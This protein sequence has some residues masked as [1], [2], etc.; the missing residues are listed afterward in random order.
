MKRMRP[1]VSTS[2]P[3][4]PK[5]STRETSEW[6]VACK[7]NIISLMSFKSISKYG[8]NDEF[9]FLVVSLVLIIPIMNKYIFNNFK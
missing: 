2:I 1:I 4:V 6:V 3:S 8:I 7:K 5:K 9:L